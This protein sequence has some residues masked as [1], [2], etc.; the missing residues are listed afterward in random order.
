MQPQ[1]LEKLT[2]ITEEEQNTLLLLASLL[3]PELTSWVNHQQAEQESESNLPSKLEQFWSFL[4]R[5][6]HGQT[7]KLL[8]P[9]ADGLHFVEIKQIIHVAG[10]ANYSTLHL[11]NGEQLIASKNLKHFEELLPSLLFARVHQSHLV[12]IQFIK[13]INTTDGNYLE[14]TNG[15]TIPLARRRKEALL[16]LLQSA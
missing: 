6:K 2:Q 8:V 5:L 12:N 13:K 16:S 9:V 4:Q 7:K 3:K 10:N 11:E 14:L 15:S 1:L